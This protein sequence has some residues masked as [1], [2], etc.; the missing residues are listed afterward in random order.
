[1]DVSEIEDVL[2][3]HR[4]LL[5]ETNLRLDRFRA[6]LAAV[7]RP[8]DVVLDLGAGVGVLGFFAC[9]AGARRVYAVE[10]S[11]A[12]DIARQIARANGFDDRI[13]FVDGSSGGYDLPEPID[14]LV[15]DL[16]G[17]CGLGR[18]GLRSIISTRDRFLKPGGSMLPA[19]IDMMIAPV[20]LPIVYEQD[21]QFWS[22]PSHGIDVS[23]VRQLAVNNRYPVRVDAPSLLA[24]PA[25][26]AHLDLARIADDHVQASVVAT[27]RRR[28]TL[29]GLCCWFAATLVD[30]L[31]IGNE[32]GRSTTNYAQAFLPIDRPV[33]LEAQD[34]VRVRVTCCRGIEFRWQVEV[35][36]SGEAEPR[37][38]F[39]HSTF[40]GTPLSAASL[41]SFVRRE[42][43]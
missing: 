1:V 26:L 33:D 32:P 21:I 38:T 23:A 8:G 30:G 40:A 34:S 22:Q 6:A 25:R 10:T 15:T 7:V 13:T 18:D 37:A 43:G 24:S 19:S 42:G 3:F 29:H 36:R 39:D 41:Q 31:E 27:A 17:T 14:V 16:F 4:F 20:E 28:G 35:V 2:R 5:G 9:V 11:V 12:L